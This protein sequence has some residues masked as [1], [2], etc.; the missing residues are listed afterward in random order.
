MEPSAFL[1]SVA[2]NNN[3]NNNKNNKMTSS[4]MG[5]VSGP[6]WTITKRKIDNEESYRNGPMFAELRYLGY[7]SIY[8]MHHKQLY[9]FT[10]R[11]T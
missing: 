2:P 6:K 9:I 10:A 3:K 5:S 11:C 4:D 8:Q 1:K 7:H